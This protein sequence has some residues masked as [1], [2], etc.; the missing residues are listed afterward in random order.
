MPLRQPRFVKRWWSP[1]TYH[2][3]VSCLRSRRRGHKIGE[4]RG[5]TQK[6]FAR[7]LFWQVFV[8]LLHFD[9]NA[10]F[11]CAVCSFLLLSVVTVS[12]RGRRLLLVA[13]VLTNPGACRLVW[14]EEADY[15]WHFA[16]GVRLGYH[17]AD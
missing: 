12:R 17:A 10:R 6:H 5:T 11:S 16:F 14:Q 4:E 3:G 8:E 15:Y 7:F 1:T 2:L 13:G 9:I